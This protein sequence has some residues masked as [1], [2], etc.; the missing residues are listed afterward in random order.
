MRYGRGGV[1]RCEEARGNMCVYIHIRLG[2]YYS[3]IKKEEELTPTLR[4]CTERNAPS[5]NDRSFGSVLCQSTYF[6][7]GDP[8]TSMVCSVRPMSPWQNQGCRLGTDVKEMLR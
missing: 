4:Q 8:S 5:F 6:A 1:K 7:A 2:T 3:R